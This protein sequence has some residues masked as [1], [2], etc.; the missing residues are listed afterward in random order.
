MTTRGEPSTIQTFW[1]VSADCIGRDGRMLKLTTQKRVGQGASSTRPYI[2]N[3]RRYFR[4]SGTDGESGE[5]RLTRRTPCLLM[6]PVLFET[7]AAHFVFSSL[8]Q[9]ETFQ[10]VRRPCARHD[11]IA[12]RNAVA[13]MPCQE[14]AG[15]IR[16]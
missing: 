5:P 16:F 15:R 8:Q 2:R 10:C 4:T 12:K 9:Q 14:K 13:I 1:Y 11:R 7:L 3:S 6:P